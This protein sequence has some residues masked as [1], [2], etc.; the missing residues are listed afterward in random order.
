[1]SPPNHAIQRDAAVVSVGRSV[2]NGVA[3]VKC[4]ELV[5]GAPL[6]AVR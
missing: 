6:M 4:L 2:G 1:M 5:E 3:F